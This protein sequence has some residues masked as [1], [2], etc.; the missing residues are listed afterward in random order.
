[1][2]MAL[3]LTFTQIE[4]DLYNLLENKNFI[5]LSAPVVIECESNPRFAQYL[6]S[7]DLNDQDSLSKV[8]PSNTLTLV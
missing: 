5:L 1:M 8:I 4:D 2:A 6:S 3:P 7:L